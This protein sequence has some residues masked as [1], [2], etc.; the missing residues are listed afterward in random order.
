MRVDEKAARG[1]GDLLALIDVMAGSQALT[2]NDAMWIQVCDYIAEANKAHAEAGK[3][4]ED[5]RHAI[6]RHLQFKMDALDMERMAAGQAVAPASEPADPQPEAS[7]P[8]AVDPLAEHTLKINDINKPG[9]VI[10]YLE[11]MRVHLADNPTVLKQFLEF[12]AK[13]A[14]VKFQDRSWAESVVNTIQDKIKEI[15]GSLEPR[16][17]QQELMP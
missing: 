11:K 13:H 2:R 14:E 4:S 12:V 10:A 16:Q 15:R 6:N 7:P 8:P 3:W 17:I 5:D 1:A 9:D